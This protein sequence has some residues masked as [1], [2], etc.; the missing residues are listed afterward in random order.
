MKLSPGAKTYRWLG[1]LVLALGGAALAVFCA[2]TNLSRYARSLLRGEQL[3]LECL[4]EGDYLE[5]KDRETVRVPY[6]L[7]N[8]SGQSLHLS[9]RTTDRAAYLD[10][11]PRSLGPW[12]EVAF[13]LVINPQGLN[14][15]R[16]FSAVVSTDSPRAPQL[17][18]SVDLFVRA[19]EVR[20][21]HTLSPVP[22]GCERLSR[23]IVLDDLPADRFVKVSRVSDPRWSVTCSRA[24]GR[25]LEAKLVGN[26]APLPAENADEARTLAF[27]LFFEGLVLPCS[28][29][30]ARRSAA[31]VQRTAAE[32][33]AT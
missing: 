8:F 21:V 10:G 23:T 11:L 26:T 5:V 22:A 13:Q 24:G 30:V 19:D 18:L 9:A 20:Q 4:L 15:R 28:E 3:A 12:E 27:S 17:P 33:R 31:V 2:D 29:K 7:K 6:R 14:G 32:R 16:T 1:L 25:K